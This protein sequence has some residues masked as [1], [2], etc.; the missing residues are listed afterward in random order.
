MGDTLMPAYVSDFIL[1][2]S[3]YHQLTNDAKI[4]CA[5]WPIS[6]CPLVSLYNCCVNNFQI[7]DE[8]LLFKDIRQL[9]CS[10]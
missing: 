8:E 4:T 6:Q 9:V 1:I 5:I 3:Q 7:N 10:L 2:V